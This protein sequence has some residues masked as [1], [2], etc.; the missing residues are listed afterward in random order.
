MGLIEDVGSFL[1]L[2]ISLA[3]AAPRGIVRPLAS[4]PLTT[5]LCPPYGLIISVGPLSPQITFFYGFSNHTTL[6]ARR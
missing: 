2:H 6:H 5:V 1:L 3:L 4:T